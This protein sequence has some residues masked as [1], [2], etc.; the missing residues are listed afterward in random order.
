[1]SSFGGADSSPAGGGGPGARQELANS[2]GSLLL[3]KR[4]GRH[5]MRRFC[6]AS[7]AAILASLS[8]LDNSGGQKI[9]LKM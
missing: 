7:R 3:V 8:T 4:P 6:L 9:L 1:M 5:D 2:N